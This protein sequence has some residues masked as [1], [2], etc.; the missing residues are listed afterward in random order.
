LA[1]FALV[2]QLPILHFAIVWVGVLNSFWKSLIYVTM[3]PSF[4]MGMRI[5]C[6]SLCCRY[7]G[8]RGDDLS[9]DE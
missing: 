5:F 2:F 8:R 3:S 7:K 9:D 6:L 4:R 1:D